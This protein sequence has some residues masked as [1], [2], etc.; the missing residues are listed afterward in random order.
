MNVPVHI[1]RVKIDPQGGEFSLNP[2]LEAS[3]MPIAHSPG[4]ALLYSI[5]KWP[6]PTIDRDAPSN[7]GEGLFTKI[8]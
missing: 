4:D 1:H 3:G 7:G 2:T 8:S 6:N 5:P